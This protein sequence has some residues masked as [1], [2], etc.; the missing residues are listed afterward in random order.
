M[1]VRNGT[2]SPEKPCGEAPGRRVAAAIGRMHVWTLAPGVL[3]WIARVR[4]TASAWCLPP[5]RAR[6]RTCL[7]RLSA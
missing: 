1:Q 2:C 3:R 4:R 5:K 6:S 7:P